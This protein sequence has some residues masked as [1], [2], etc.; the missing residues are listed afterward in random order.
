MHMDENFIKSAQGPS[1]LLLMLPAAALLLVETCEKKRS[2]FLVVVCV[3]L[4]KSKS[5]CLG[6]EAE[7]ALVLT[8]IF[9]SNGAAAEESCVCYCSAI[10]ASRLRGTR[11][12]NHG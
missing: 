2:W 10:C 3:F 1:C 6:S 11:N 4:A 9:G 5:F 12:N 8:V 7:A